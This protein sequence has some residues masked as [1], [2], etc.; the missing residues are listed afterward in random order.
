MPEELAQKVS[1][2]LTHSI[3]C[4]ASFT[5]L[6]G[7][8]AI[9][10]DQHQVEMV[11]KAYKER[12][13]LLVQGLNKIPGVHCQLPQG[14]FYAFPNITPFGK[15]SDWL[16]DYLLD[17]AGVALLPGTSFGKY[18]EGYLRLC[19]ATSIENLKIALNRIGSALSSLK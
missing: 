4:T 7:I 1:L 9:Q 19:F 17:E 5:Q 18:G 12:R 6:A 14:A 13:D 2:L 8:E 15:N 3:G 11:V 16:A 10:G